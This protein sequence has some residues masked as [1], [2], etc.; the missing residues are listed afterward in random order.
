MASLIHRSRLCH[1]DPR[2]MV[3]TPINTYLLQLGVRSNTTIIS[4]SSPTNGASQGDC[5]RLCRAGPDD[6]ATG[7]NGRAG[8]TMRRVRA[9]MRPGLQCAAPLLLQQLLQHLSHPVQL[10]LPHPIR[11]VRARVHKPLQDQLCVINHAGTHRH[12]W[13]QECR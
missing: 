13:I 6:P 9:G 2:R 4:I 11:L 10:L 7:A 3:R 8:H 12:A 1:P 5:C